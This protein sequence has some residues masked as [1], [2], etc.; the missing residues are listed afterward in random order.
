M[1]INNCDKYGNSKDYM[2]KHESCKVLKTEMVRKGEKLCLSEECEHNNYI[3]L[4]LTT[5]SK[6]K[7]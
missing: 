2:Q 3:N 5:G 1:Q 4:M 7:P 6:V